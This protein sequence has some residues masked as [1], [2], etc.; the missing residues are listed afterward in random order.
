MKFHFPEP[1]DSAGLRKF[2]VVTGLGFSI[3]FGLFFPWLL[4]LALPN[5]PFVI[6]G[7]FITAGLI[8]PAG[9][10]PVYR[11]WMGTAVIVGWLN[12][13]LLLTLVFLLVLTPIGL[14]RRI[15]G[16]DTLGRRFSRNAVSYRKPSEQ[17]EAD[18]VERPF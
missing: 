5:W 2:G 12:S 16:S 18:H 8:A 10:K 17:R 4:D 6:G 14:L 13:Q 7:L 15:F 3:L 1:P 11:V 9:L